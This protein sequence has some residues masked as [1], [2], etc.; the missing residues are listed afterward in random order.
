[1]EAF[2]ETITREEFS[3]LLNDIYAP[4][5]AASAVIAIGDDR[6][7]IAKDPG[8]QDCVE[9][10]LAK[11]GSVARR[12]PRYWRAL[13]EIKKTSRPL[14]GLKIAIDPGHLGGKWA[15]MEER[16]FTI[17]DAKPVTEGDLTL[18]VA[19][20]LA[21]RLRAL[22]ASVDLVRSSDVPL[23]GRRPGT[24]HAA[25]RE[26]F[27]RGAAEPPR[28]ENIEWHAE[29]LFYRASEIRARGLLVNRELR[30]DLVLCLHF[31]AEAWGDPMQPALTDR[32]HFHAL[33]NGCYA[34]SELN[35]DDVRFE[36]LLKLLSHSFDEELALSE[37]VAT[38][39][40]AATGL[41]PY[42]YTTGN[43]RAVGK[44]GYVWA[45]NLLANRIY[46]CPVI[47]LEPYVMNCRDV[48]DRIQAGDYEGERMIAGVNRPSIFREYAD[49]VAEGLRAYSASLKASTAG[50]DVEGAAE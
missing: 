6:A 7:W 30:P 1:M 31:N 20:L 29:R 45:R 25:A 28:E 11:P 49:S 14:Q 50:V 18:T 4:A 16:W 47:F 9:L 33:V 38:T 8:W 48:F 23:T 13:S 35:F 10:R 21:P 5:N 17:G 44:T 26:E 40:A 41:P 32:N 42:Q 39:M 27:A 37:S 19:K 46:E 12:T 24:L 34:A 43:A 15:R 22:G 36:M 3:R 2:R